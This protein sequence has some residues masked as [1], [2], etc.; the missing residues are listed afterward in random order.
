[1]PRDE[2]KPALRAALR[3]NEIGSA[4]PYQISFAK[5]GNSGG[6]FGFMQ[7]DLAAGQP[8]VH[9]T[10]RQA[11][12]AAGMDAATIGNLEQRLSQKG[13]GPNVITDAERSAIDAALQASS[14]LVDAMDE[15]ILQKVYGGLDTCIVSAGDVG[16]SIAPVAQLYIAMW[17]NMTGPPD[18]IL[19]CLQG[20]GV[21]NPVSETD[22][23]TYLQ[24]QK[25][26][27]EN[28]KNWPHMVASAQVGAKQL[29]SLVA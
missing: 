2:Y 7:G 15:S 24:V 12:Q 1:M 4:S 17:I 11:M 5:K 13:I 8:I 26:F 23:Q 28:P 10:F 20:P 25:Y 27:V 6:S 9:T 21:G 22:I 18:K 29:P 14:A 19:I 16:R 3:F